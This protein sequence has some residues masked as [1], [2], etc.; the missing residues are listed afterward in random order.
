MG[1]LFTFI[2]CHSRGNGNPGMLIHDFLDSH[3]RGNDEKG[4]N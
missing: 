4:H 2:K 1:Q 3:F